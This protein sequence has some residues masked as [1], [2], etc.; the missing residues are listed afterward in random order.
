MSLDRRG[1][2]ILQ[3]RVFNP[4]ERGTGDRAP[5]APRRVPLP[6]KFLNFLYQNGEFLCSSVPV[7]LID[8][9]TANRYDRKL[10]HLSCKKSTT[11]VGFMLIAVKVVPYGM[12]N[13]A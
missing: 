12:K 1:S 2:K 10:S 5:E 8:A 4:S 6:R 3:G 7:I 9:V 13:L 11:L